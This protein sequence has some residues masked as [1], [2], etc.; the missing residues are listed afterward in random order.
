[1]QVSII[2][3]LFNR[4]D[5]TRAYLESLER[6]LHRW[7]YEVILIDDG[8]TDGTREF[9]ATLSAPRYRVVLNGRPLG[10]AANNNLGARLARAPLLGLLNNDLVL[11]PRWLEPMARLATMLP[12]VA[13]VGNV[14]REPVGG[15]IDHYGIVFSADGDAL[16]AGRNTCVP[17]QE[18]YLEWAAITAACCVLRRDVFRQ[19]GGFDEAFRNGFEDVDFCLRAGTKGYRHYVA[20]RSVVYHHVSASPGRKESEEANLT[21]FRQRWQGYLSTEG[22]RQ[23]TVADRQ[24]AGRRYLWKHRWQPWRYNFWRAGRAV[25]QIWAPD[26]ASRRLDVLPRLLLQLGETVR[27]R[28]LEKRQLAA[29]SSVVSGERPAPILMVVGDTAQGSSRSGVPTVVRCLAGALGRLDAPVKLVGWQRQ[30][31]QL[32]L[33][34]HG[35][36]VGLDADGLQTPSDWRCVA[37]STPALCNPS[38]EAWDDPFARSPPLHQLPPPALPPPGSWVLLPEV[39]SGEDAASLV[40]YVHHYGWRLAVILHDTLAPNEPE[41]FPPEVP[42]QRALYLRACSRADRLL[43][44]SDF[45]AADWALFAAAKHLPQPRV[46]ICKLAADTCTRTRSPG[47]SLQRSPEGTV[48]VLCV[49]SVEARKNHLALLAAYDLAVAARPGLR[50][51][52]CFVGENRAGP[53]HARAAIHEATLRY[54]GQVTWYEWVGYTAL[55]K[56][57]ETCDFT[58][59]PSGLEGFGLP[60][61][62]SLWF[63]RPCICAN[64]GAMDELAYGG[65]CL[66]VDVRD[67]EALAEAMVELADSPQRRESLAQE[68]DTR[69]LRS[70]EEYAHEVLNILRNDP[71]TSM[72]NDRRSAR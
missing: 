69:W 45:T 18:P 64:F 53:G 50:L 3:P 57:Y 65:G 25:E 41:L 30:A 13:C 11:T 48:R 8:S 15:L 22:R 23:V 24:H 72:L 71:G 1:M 49:S 62:E 14:Q 40:D 46:S 37:G 33:L 6:T 16:H 47:P 32:S 31:R 10:F 26:P 43:P 44:V 36:S 19:M 38:A 34:P 51:E 20:N 7:R 21:L 58:V 9:L 28:R 39:L 63:R 54:P 2:T 5:L 60:I 68:I 42:H 52:L 4:L 61:T 67:P 56:L 27:L 66:T 12:D 29:P 55:Q 70:W 59:Y 35:F 17:P